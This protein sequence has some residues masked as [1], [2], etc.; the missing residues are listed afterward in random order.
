[1]VLYLYLYRLISI[2]ILLLI[3]LKLILIDFIDKYMMNN[4]SSIKLKLYR[5][6]VNVGN[7]NDLYFI[8]CGAAITIQAAWR[9]Y[10]CR[11]ALRNNTNKTMILN[12]NNNNNN[13]STIDEELKAEN[14]MNSMNIVNDNKVNC[15]NYFKNDFLCD[16]IIN[17]EGKQYKCHSVVLWCNSGYFKKVFETDYINKQNH[18]YY[19]EV[20]TSSKCWEIAHLFIYGH[21]VVIEKELLND[22][23]KLVEQLEIKELLKEIRNTSKTTSLLSY[24]SLNTKYSTKFKTIC[25]GSKQPLQIISSYYLFFKCVINFHMANKLTLNETLKYLSSS[26]IN[27]SKMNEKELFNSIY[28]LKTKMKIQNSNLIP[29]LI[30]NYLKTKS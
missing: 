29:E 13:E 20:Y 28:L 9:G 16:V 12:K 25:L 4:L 15:N 18:K 10:L 6:L 3:Q 27:Y 14:V 30:N 2:I 19:F 17:V 8:L 22:L 11:K 5:K 1:M 24:S 23:L 26:Y 21:S 7:Q